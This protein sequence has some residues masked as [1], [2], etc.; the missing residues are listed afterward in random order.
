MKQLYKGKVIA[1]FKKIT[2][3]P[4]GYSVDLDIVTHPGAVL[5]VPFISSDKIIILKQYR[6]VIKAYLYELPAGTLKKGE[7]KLSCAKRELVEETGYSARKLIKLG[8]IYP[9]PGYSTEEIT[10]YK[11]IG[12]RK[13]L[14]HTEEDE[15]IK[16]I[17]L[18]KHKIKKLFKNGRIQDAKTIC[19]L[20]MC[21]WLR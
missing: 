8:K 10:I 18:N 20:S 11:A 19:A 4:N 15:V 21:G 12:L 16:V 17:I 2:C 5:I 6:P 13:A 14:A 9:V 1:L 3:L 7:I